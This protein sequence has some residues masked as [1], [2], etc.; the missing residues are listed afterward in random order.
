MRKFGPLS[1]STRCCPTRRHRLKASHNPGND[2]GPGGPAAV[3][4]ES[5]LRKIV[6]DAGLVLASLIVGFLIL[7]IGARAANGVPVFST[8]NFVSNMLDIVRRNTGAMV[9]DPTLGWNLRDDLN[10]GRAFAT[11][12]YGVR[13]NGATVQPIPQDAVLAVGDS[14]TVG[15]GVAND[16]TWPAALERLTGKPVV[17]AGAGAWGVDQMV[18]RA[19]TLVP[20]LHPRRLIVGILAD[21][22]LRNSYEIY[23]G[24][25]KPYFDVVDGKAALRGV[26]VPHV[27]E[28]NIGLN[29]KRKI[30]GHSYLIYWTLRQLGYEARWVADDFRYKRV[31][32]NEDGVE[33]SCA[34]MERLA[35]VA[36][37]N[38]LG[39]AVVMEYGANEVVG[40][41]PPWYAPPVLVCAKAHGFATVDAFP[42]LHSIFEKEPERFKTLWIDEDGQLG[43]MSAA[44]NA[45]VAH[46]VA[47]QAP[48]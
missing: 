14:F 47:K 33:I 26:P 13:M 22:S 3:R 44:G 46:L 2:R 45:L 17:N 19:E 43:H 37:D 27:T 42:V 4:T 32:S 9:H 40:K 30:L 10:F 39:I 25:Y 7:E 20:I 34:L 41:E 15:S 24:G 35:R 21:D 12:A 18:L 38:G 48:E 6:L 31:H 8:A 29:L 23:G 5:A 11:G 36:A 28:H 1:S 16:E